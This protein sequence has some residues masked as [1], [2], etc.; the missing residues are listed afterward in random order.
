MKL[1]PQRRHQIAV[2]LYRNDTPRLF[3]QSFRQSTLTRPDLDD[4]II[5]RE[6]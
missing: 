3:Q 2:E 4:D 5:F 1:N 6:T